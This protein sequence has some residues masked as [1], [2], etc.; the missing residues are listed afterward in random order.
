[1]EADIEGYQ[2]KVVSTRVAPARVTFGDSGIPIR[3]GKTLP[4][5][6]SRQWSAPA[7]QYV[8]RWYLVQPDTREVL[9]EGPARTVSLF[10]LQALTEITDDVTVPIPLQPG[11]YQI[12]YSLNGLLGGQFDVEA[13]EA[14]AEAA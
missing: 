8:E 5:R 9:H 1:M 13:I 14:P 6:L 7:G 10:G 12:F 3:K 11:S 4:F 2:R